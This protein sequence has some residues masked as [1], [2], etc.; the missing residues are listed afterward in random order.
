[1]VSI[2]TGRQKGAVKVVIYAQEGWGKSS[3]ASL[4]PEPLTIDTEGSTKHLDIRRIDQIPKS[5]PEF[6]DILSFVEANRPCRT[7]IID[8]ADWLEALIIRDLCAKRG[9][10]GI[11]C[12]DYGKGYVYLEE[13]F[14]KLLNR[15]EDLVQSGI[16]IVMCA[17]VITK[18]FTSPTE[19]GTWDR[20]ELKLQ[21]KD[22]AKLKEWADVILFGRFRDVVMAVD[23][24][25]KKLKAKGGE[26]RIMNTIRTAAWDAKSRFDLPPEIVFEKGVLPPMLAEIMGGMPVPQP[27]PVMPVPESKIEQP[28]TQTQQAAP[29]PVKPQRPQWQEGVDER[30]I[31]LMDNAFI[32]E[33]AIREAVS[34]KGWFPIDMPISQYPADFVNQMLIGGWEQM[35]AFIK[36]QGLDLPY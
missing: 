31:R 20:Y 10:D 18:S 8:T 23:K 2:S 17:H 24:E 9:W 14:G 27:A 33:S 7:L 1:M 34:R 5:Y 19:N 3:L 11:E 21:K 15:L 12:K 4:F 16:N 22:C 30:L 13:E 32:T 29:Q 35:L 28:K 36:D 6:L 25:G 26:V